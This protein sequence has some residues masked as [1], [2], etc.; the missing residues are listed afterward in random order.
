MSWKGRLVLYLLDTSVFIDAKNKY[1]PIER[2]PQFWEWLIHNGELNHLKIPAE[3]L[4]EIE[5]GRKED[6]LFEWIKKHGKTLLLGEDVNESLKNR[7][8]EQGYANDL[9]DAEINNLGNDPFLIAYAM[10]ESDRCVVTLEVS[11]PSKT[12]A[13]RRIPDV[14]TTFNIRCI[15]T[16][17]LIR[18]L[19]FKIPT[20]H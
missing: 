17:E 4:D 7:V 9:T 10:A 6:E 13:N 14:C 19:D 3:I 8:I 16:F 18:E 20:N 1:Y 12:R 11:R 2:V 15:N 5:A